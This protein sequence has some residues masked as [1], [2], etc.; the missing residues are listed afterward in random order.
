MLKKDGIFLWLYLFTSM[1]NLSLHKLF[2]E[3]EVYG[4]TI[5]KVIKFFFYDFMLNGL[6]NP[7]CF[8][9]GWR[10]GWGK[11]SHAA[12]KSVNSACLLTK[13]TL[14]YVRY[15]ISINT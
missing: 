14:H 11:L 9:L 4:Q 1:D 6:L 13:I 8:F 12:Q 7:N 5:E 15:C 3:P 2:C 10:G